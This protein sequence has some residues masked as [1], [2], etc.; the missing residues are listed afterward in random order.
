MKCPI[1][2][3]EKNQKNISK[4]C[5]LKIL[6]K[7]LSINDTYSIFFLIIFTKAYVVG[8]HLNCLNLLRQFK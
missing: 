3:S 8:T 7:V 5:L 4:C 1:L 6:P 2:F